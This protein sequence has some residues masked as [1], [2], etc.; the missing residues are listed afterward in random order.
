MILL[1]SEISFSSS[2]LIRF[3]VI[4]FSCALFEGNRWYLQVAIPV[5]PTIRVLV[6]FAEYEEF[7][8]SEVFST[9]PCSPGIKSPETQTSSSWIQWI[10]A[11][12]HQSY[13][14]TSGPSC[15]VEDVQ[16]PFVILPDYTWTTPEAKKTIKENKNMSMM[17][18]T[19]WVSG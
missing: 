12:Y 2:H 4:R 15:H 5:V 16:D 14:T 17:G 11:S 18:R 6:I 7:Q 13:S 1:L 10:K 19:E 3:L 8:P 9:P